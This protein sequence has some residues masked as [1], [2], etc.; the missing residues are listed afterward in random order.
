MIYFK[1]KNIPIRKK[2]VLAPMLEFTNLPFRLLAKEYGA[3]LTYTE[4]IHVPY[5]L[6]KDLSEISI[7]KSTIEDTPTAV[8]LVG[9][10]TKKETITAAHLLD[11]SKSFDIIDFN[12]GCPSQ[13]VMA[14]NAG[15]KLLKDISKVIP[16]IK[17][18]KE[19]TSKPITVKTRI[20]YKQ[21]NIDEIINKFE[22]ANI[23]AIAIHARAS[24][25][26][27]NIKSNSNLI[28]K[29]ILKTSTPI[30]YN[31]DINENNFKEFLDFPEIMIGRAALG[32]L[33]IFKQINN[34]LKTGD[35]LK[36]NELEGVEELKKYLELCDKYNYDWLHIK[37]TIIPFIHGFEGASNLRNS[38][39]KITSNKQFKEIIN[40]QLM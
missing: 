31:G 35:L 24:D 23:D 18:I 5:L 29:L 17:E 38:L 19:T 33:F 36:K 30:I 21:N 20:G 39:S 15:S 13:K 26:F 6:N 22:K 10:F 14:G 4:M 3:G 7:L 16:I 2:A 25:E 8:Q 1:I 40:K 11:K 9:D 28:R 34:F 12:F 27:Y 37:K 32:N